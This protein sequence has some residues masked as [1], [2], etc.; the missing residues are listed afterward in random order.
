MI[1]ISKRFAFIIYEKNNLQEILPVKNKLINHWPS[2]YGFF[3]FYS[4]FYGTFS[5]STSV[6]NLLTYPVLS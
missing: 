4:I 1:S 6:V 2:V 3:A 5:P